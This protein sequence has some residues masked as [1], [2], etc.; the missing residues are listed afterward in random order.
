MDIIIWSLIGVLVG[1]AL[2]VWRFTLIIDL[3]MRALRVIHDHVDWMEYAMA[4]DNGPSQ[5]DMML[6]WRKWTFKQFYPW[7]AGA[8]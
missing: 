1:L 4:F 6:D 5:H 3:R 7:L 2:V 8:V